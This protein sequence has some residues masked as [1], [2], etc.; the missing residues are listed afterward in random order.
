MVAGAAA[1]IFCWLVEL[2]QLTGLPAEWSEHSIVARLVLGRQFDPVDLLRYPVGVLPLVVLHAVL[3][4]RGRCHRP[5]V[6]WLDGRQQP[7]SQP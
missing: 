1:I 2:F 6:E 7:S 3:V 5:A 4:R